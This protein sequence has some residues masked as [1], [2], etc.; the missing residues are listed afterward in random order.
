MVGIAVQSLT[1]RANARQSA[2]R[3]SA[4]YVFAREKQ[5][6]DLFIYVGRGRR[7][8]GGWGRPAS[9][10]IAA[11]LRNIEMTGRKVERL[12]KGFDTKAEL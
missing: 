5:R 12:D 7:T 10:R 6:T 4:E 3:G 1:V 9:I 11:R 2:I 8:A